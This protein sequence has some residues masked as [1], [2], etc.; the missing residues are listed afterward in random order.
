ME[1]LKANRD[2]LH[3]SLAAFETDCP[4]ET[5]MIEKARESGF[6]DEDFHVGDEVISACGSVAGVILSI[7]GNEALVTWACRGKSVE[8]IENLAHIEHDWT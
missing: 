5:A 3:R 1:K 2:M 7:T 6:H 8:P 4:K